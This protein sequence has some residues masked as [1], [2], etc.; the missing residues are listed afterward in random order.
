MHTWQ[1][2]TALSTKKL[3]RAASVA[4]VLASIASHAHAVE[5]A[6]PDLRG[7]AVTQPE[8]PGPAPTLDGGPPRGDRKDRLRPIPH[9]VLMKS[10]RAALGENAPSQLRLTPEQSEKIQS[11]DREHRRV[12][13]SYLQ[14]HREEIA[15]LRRGAQR[16][17]SKGDLS[18]SPKAGSVKAKADELRANAPNPDHPRAKIWEVL[19]PAQRDAVK[20]QLDAYQTKVSEGLAKKEAARRLGK[21]RGNANTNSPASSSPAPDAPPERPREKSKRPLDRENTPKPD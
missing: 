2:K 7:P 9:P 8:T 10:I 14:E 18:E 5:P 21:A 20:T 4:C 12:M 6:K 19:S 16:K 17:A 13:E 3:R 11:I 15:G 1:H